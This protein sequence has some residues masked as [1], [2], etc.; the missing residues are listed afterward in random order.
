MSIGNSFRQYLRNTLCS[1]LSTGG[2]RPFSGCDAQAMNSSRTQSTHWH[3]F[4]MRSDVNAVAKGGNGLA[5]AMHTQ[6]DCST[7]GLP[8]L[9]RSMSAP[10][11]VRTLSIVSAPAIWA[12]VRCFGSGGMPSVTCCGSCPIAASC[13]GM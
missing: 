6:C 7:P 9:L 12:G 1:T 13:S 2:L 4:K 10:R 3:M 8:S 5:S 11:E